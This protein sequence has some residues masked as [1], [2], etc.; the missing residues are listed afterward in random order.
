MHDD[1]MLLNSGLNANNAHMAIPRTTIA[2]FASDIMPYNDPPLNLY[3][4]L[5]TSVTIFE[6]A[7]SDRLD[8]SSILAR[9]VLYLSNSLDELSV[10]QSTSSDTD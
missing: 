3:D 1:I 10:T 8:S 4:N 5:S 9:T 6:S 7:A 2:H